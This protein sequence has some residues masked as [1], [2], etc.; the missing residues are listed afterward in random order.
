MAPI[1]GPVQ[2]VK[3]SGVATAVARIQSLAQELPYA[4]GAAIKK[5]VLMRSLAETC[6]EEKL[7]FSCALIPFFFLISRTPSILYHH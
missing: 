1:P 2:W 5:N 6:R 4:K 3:G 7:F